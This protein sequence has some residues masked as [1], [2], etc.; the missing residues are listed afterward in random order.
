MTLNTHEEQGIVTMPPG[1]VRITGG[2]L[3]MN[4]PNRLGRNYGTAL[5]RSC[6]VTSR[7]TRMLQWISI[8]YVGVALMEPI[9]QLSIGHSIYI[10]DVRYSFWKYWWHFVLNGA[11][12]KTTADISCAR[13]KSCQY[14]TFG[15]TVQFRM[16]TQVVEEYL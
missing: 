16:S 3:E 11:S 7:K 2:Q 14:L 5:F 9:V 1:L 10:L 13:R 8:N 12:Y 15:I 6:A 4:T